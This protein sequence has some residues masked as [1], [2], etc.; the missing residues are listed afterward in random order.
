M[1][2]LTT[3]ASAGFT[4]KK[5]LLYFCLMFTLTSVLQDMVRTLFGIN[6]TLARTTH[7][8]VAALIALYFAFMSKK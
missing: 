7:Y 6:L 5:W 8:T 1:I 3:S 4:F 2:R